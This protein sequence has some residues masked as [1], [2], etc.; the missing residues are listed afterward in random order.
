MKKNLNYRIPLLFVGA[1]LVFLLVTSAHLTGSKL[2][3]ACVGDSITFGARLDNPDSDSYPAHLQKLLGEGYAVENY[4]VGSLTL[5]RKGIPSVWNELPKIMSANPNIVVISLGTNDTCGY[6]TCGD[7]KCWEYKDE[8]ESDYRDLIDEFA[9][10]PSDP[11]IFL[12][13][14][15]P[16]V[17][18]TPGLDAE[19]V[20]GLQARKPRLQEL[21]DTIKRVAAEKNVH[22]I[23]L[24]EPLDHRPELFTVSDGVHPNKEGYAAV[25]ALVAKQLTANK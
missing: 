4:G 7:R 17:L 22:F 9:K 15:T 12:C 10:L 19:R 6:G 20:A 1:L 14:P 18:E 23:D 24:N 2:K 3:V 16:M 11:Q 25:A 21:I 13:A 8:F 5:L